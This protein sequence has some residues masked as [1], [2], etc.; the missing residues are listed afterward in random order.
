MQVSG[1]P[2]VSYTYD[3][4]NRLTGLSKQTTMIALA[5]DDANRRTTLTLP[6]GILVE[7]GYDD[8]AQLTALTYKLGSTTL[9][10]RLHV[11]RHW[12]AYRPGWG[13]RSNGIALCH[14]FGDVR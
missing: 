7:Y 2:A 14:G 3:N 5:Y 13:I 4:A 1:Q 11:R 12:T 6:N 9:G 8:D 10:N